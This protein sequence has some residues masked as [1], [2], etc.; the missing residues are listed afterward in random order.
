MSIRLMRTSVMRVLLR[1]AILGGLAMAGVVLLSSSEP[2]LQATA[3]SQANA[4]K[5]K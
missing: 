4:A 1:G 2:G 5:K 3:G